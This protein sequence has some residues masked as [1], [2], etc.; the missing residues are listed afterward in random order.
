MIRTFSMMFL[1]LIA[2]APL[3]AQ[4]AVTVVAVPPLATPSKGEK[5][6][7]DLAIAWE[8]TQLIV[9]DLRV[10][11]ELM[12]LPPD[13]KDVY[14]YPE[15]TA[16]SFPKWRAA[17]ASA[18][19]TGFVQTRPDGRLTFGCYVYDAKSG[20]ELG[21][22][23][24]VVAASDLRRA[25]HR[26]SGL[27]YQSL[28]GAPGMFD[29]KI[30]YV[31]ETGNAANAVR[32]IAVMDSDGFNHDYATKGE[33]MVLSPRLSPRAQSVAFVSFSGGAPNIKLLDLTSGSTTSL[34]A[35]D[36][37]SFSPRFSPDGEAIAFTMIQGN[38]AD[39]YVADAAGGPPVRLTTAPGID[40]AP[41]FS[42]DGKRIVFES[43][44]SGSQQL[45]VM[46]ADGSGQRRISFGATAFAAPSWSPDGEW[47]A[48]V[49]RVSGSRRIG[50]MR[51]DGREARLLTD[52]S[53]DDSPAWAA[54]SREILFERIDSTGRPGLHRVALDGGEPRRMSIPQPGSD[55]DWS[56]VIE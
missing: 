16:P 25:A 27:A 13:Q 31:A 29:T 26:C 2:A 1:P 9:T 5:A 28:T 18:L 19:V 45:Y 53:T 32:R 41:S 50:V 24:F 33:T 52:G 49:A 37:I 44:R 39:I 10:T 51:A 11:S 43:D 3:S 34:I 4:Q 38:N 17:G 56:G 21:R 15:V 22:K 12:P 23:G 42:P 35:G 7:E 40:T 14:S 6:N 55:P 54:S 36:P 46:N 20:R 47:V 8:A 48:Y 30:S